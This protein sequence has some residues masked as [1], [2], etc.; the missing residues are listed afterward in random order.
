[1]TGIL[2]GLT[3]IEG[4]A[5]VAAP[6]G[7]M[8][9]A[10]MGA[11]VIRFD[12]IG[13]GL[14]YRRWPVTREGKSLYWPSLNK[15]K[16]SIAIDIRNPKGQE[17][18]HAL[19]AQSKN[20]LTN[21]PARGWLD[22]DKLKSVTPDLVMINVQGN[23]DGS[24]ELDYTVNCAAGFPDITGPADLDQPVNHVLPAWDVSTGLYAALSFLAADRHRLQT[25]TGQLV[26]IALSDVA[27]A[28][29]ANLGYFAEAAINGETRP[30]IGN[31]MLGSFGRDFPTKDGRRVMI[32]AITIRQWTG[33][34]EATGTHDAVAQV[35]KE[36]G[37]DFSQEGDRYHGRGQLFEII[38]AWCAAHN[39]AEVKEKFDANGV[40]W[41]PYRTVPDLLAEDPRA[42]DAN[43]VFGRV[44][45]PGIGSY[46]A[47]GSPLRFSALDKDAPLLAP[48]LGQH[49]DEV[50]LDKL[51]LSSTELG[52]L[53]DERIVAGTDDM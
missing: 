29:V 6:L 16:K 37:L 8:T 43:P 13:G 15:G 26:Q 49:T 11:E 23:P 51:G 33:L 14:D 40:C 32:V 25:G 36:L 28:T 41:G 19:I 45:Q 46:L 21:F 39:L 7:G 20:F 17:L 30:R 10:Q 9:L 3:I 42:S 2:S 4:S 38:G 27:F 44:T 22:Y 24:S 5:F 12:M 34:L 52:K 48:Q 53:H 50:L 1:M 31:D 18:I 35:E 47:P